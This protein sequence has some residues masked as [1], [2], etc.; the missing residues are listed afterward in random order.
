MPCNV[1]CVVCVVCSVCNN[2][3]HSRPPPH[4]QQTKAKRLEELVAKLQEEDALLMAKILSAS[5]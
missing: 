2:K 5:Q 1:W 4:P 3:T